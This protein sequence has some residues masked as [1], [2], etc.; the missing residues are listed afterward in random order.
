MKKLLI[1][2]FCLYFLQGIAQNKTDYDN[3]VGK[4]MKFYNNNQADSICN[5][6]ADTWGEARK[7][8]WTP[9]KLK[10]ARD[11]FGIM[12]SYKFMDGTHGDVLLYRVVF[13]KSIHAMGLSLDKKSKLLTF[14]FKT[15]SDAI[16]KLLLQNDSNLSPKEIATERYKTDSIRVKNDAHNVH[17]DY[18]RIEHDN[19]RVQHDS[20]ELK[21]HSREMKEDMIKMK[22][23]SIRMD[24]SVK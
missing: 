7:T 15:T 3:V 24:E 20:A 8:L 19:A 10:E 2:L 6:F 18:R 14:R 16:E 9:E 12:K 5:L 13:E 21:R 22:D 11:K 23:D 17:S 1:A 4:F